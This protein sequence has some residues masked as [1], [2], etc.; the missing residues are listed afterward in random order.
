M[1]GSAG[2]RPFGAVEQFL[3]PAACFTAPKGRPIRIGPA[4]RPGRTVARSAPIGYNSLIMARLR[5]LQLLVWCL[6]F[7]LLG[8]GLP[9]AAVWRCAH[10]AQLVTTLPAS[11]S[12]M[13]CRMAGHKMMACC[14]SASQATPQTPRRAAVQA[15]PCKPRLTANAPTPAARLT[16]SRTPLT[17]TD[18]VPADFPRVRPDLPSALLLTASAPRGPPPLPLASLAHASTYGLRAPPLS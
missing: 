14:R 3:I 6:L 15:P 4:F 2:G 5:R 16:P 7:P 12:A 10:A 8:T 9:H 13:P 18:A 1:S 11:P 17:G